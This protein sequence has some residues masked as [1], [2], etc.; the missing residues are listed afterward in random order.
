MDYMHNDS[1]VLGMG[2][3]GMGA[4]DKYHVNKAELWFHVQQGYMYGTM[5]SLKLSRGHML[6]SGI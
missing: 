1:T 2:V 6:S 4:T 3:L 5:N